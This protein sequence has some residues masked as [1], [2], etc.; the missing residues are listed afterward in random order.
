ALRRAIDALSAPL[1]RRWIWWD[2]PLPAVRNARFADLIED[3]PADVAWNSPQETARLL[4]MMSPVNLAKVEAAR[5]SGPRMVGAM[6][7]RTRRTAD[8]QRI[9]RVEVRFDDVAGCLRPPAGGSSRQ[10]I[11]VVQGRT[12]RSRLV[13]ARETARLMGLDDSYRLPARY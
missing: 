11:L 10:S 6:D 3:S 7:R 4:S 5:A 1:R 2:M 13:S 9:Q 12:V 8:G